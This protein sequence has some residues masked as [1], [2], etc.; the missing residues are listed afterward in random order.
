MTYREKII[1]VYMDFAKGIVSNNALSKIGIVN[2]VNYCRNIIVSNIIRFNEPLI[3]IYE[4]NL[5]DAIIEELKT[6]NSNYSKV[7]DEFVRES[8]IGDDYNQIF[9]YIKFKNLIDYLNIKK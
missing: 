5:I 9:Y 1:N 2:D 3:Y 8:I 7:Y 6:T 4:N